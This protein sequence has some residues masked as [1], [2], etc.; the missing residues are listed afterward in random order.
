MFSETYDIEPV[1]ALF[2]RYMWHMKQYFEIEDEQAWLV[3]AN[4]Y[5]NLYQVE[6]ERKIYVFT[7]ESEISGFALVNRTY[8]FNSAGSVMA[9]FYIAPEEQCKGHGQELANFTFAQQPGMWEVFVA[10]GNT[11]AFDFWK[12]VISEYT[13]DQ[14]ELQS[15][16]FYDGTGISFESA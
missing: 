5:F 10:S 1:R 13:N 4:S 3:R 7:T 15:S 12:K 2:E 9:E 16:D 8:R 6:P 14:Y 11:G